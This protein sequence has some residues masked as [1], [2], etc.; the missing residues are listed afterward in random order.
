MVYFT[1]NHGGGYQYRL[2]P[3]ED[4]LTEECF[5]KHPL[6]FVRGLQYLQWNN[7]SRLNI[8]GKLAISKSF[9]YNIPIFDTAY[10][11]NFI[12]RYIC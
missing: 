10:L 7:G 8:P 9:S 5:Q 2:C 12:P 3:L 1:A 6:D 11:G 4:E